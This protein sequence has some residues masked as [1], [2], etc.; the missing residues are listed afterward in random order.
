M[1]LKDLFRGICHADKVA[2]QAI[3]SP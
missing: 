3:N 1:D 2:L